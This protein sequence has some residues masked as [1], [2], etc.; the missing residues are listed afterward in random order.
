MWCSQRVGLVLPARRCYLS[1]QTRRAVNCSSVLSAYFRLLEECTPASLPLLRAPVPYRAEHVRG[2]RIGCIAGGRITAASQA[3]HRQHQ[4]A[5]AGGAFDLPATYA[6]PDTP[7][8]SVDRS[9]RWKTIEPDESVAAASRGSLRPTTCTVA[10]AAAS[11][12]A[13]AR[14]MPPVPQCQN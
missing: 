13:A 10:P 12:C 9:R 14:P 1:K 7:A 2:G 11:A 4:V 8:A 5:A 3:A 6:I